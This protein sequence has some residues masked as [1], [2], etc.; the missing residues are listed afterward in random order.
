[1]IDKELV[2]MFTRGLL[3]ENNI[4]NDFGDTDHSSDKQIYLM[5]TIQRAKSMY[6]ELSLKQSGHMMQ[7]NICIMELEA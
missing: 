3:C 7:E 5:W 1:M 6:A 2:R 4:Q